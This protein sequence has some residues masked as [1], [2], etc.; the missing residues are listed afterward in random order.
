MLT[1]QITPVDQQDK[2]AL[3][4]NKFIKNTIYGAANACNNISHPILML[5][6]QGNKVKPI[7]LR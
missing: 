4:E 1:N 7:L 6:K 2:Q 5:K 3:A